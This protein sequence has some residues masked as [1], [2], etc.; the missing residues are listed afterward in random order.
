MNENTGILEELKFIKKDYDRNLGDIQIHQHQGTK[1]Y[2]ACQIKIFMDKKNLQAEI[3]K[4]IKFQFL[5]H[6]NIF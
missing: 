1:D 5:Y 4:N 3:E 6:V 2:Y